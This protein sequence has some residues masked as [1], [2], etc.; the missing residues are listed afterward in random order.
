[1]IG[2]KTSPA[3]PAPKAESAKGPAPDD[4]A[5]PP[6]P[7]EEAATE[8]VAT[9]PE[10]RDEAVST[11]PD[12]GTLSGLKRKAAFRGSPPSNQSAGS[13]RE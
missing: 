7:S 10:L 3:T 5:S 13:D 11:E 9:S 1:M 8:P 2:Y 6:G 4:P 12:S